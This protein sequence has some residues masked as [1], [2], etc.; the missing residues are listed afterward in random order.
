MKA[1]PLKIL[2]PILLVLAILATLVIL[3]TRPRY[4]GKDEETTDPA[5]YAAIDT[6]ETSRIEDSAS[7]SFLVPRPTVRVCRLYFETTAPVTVDIEI[8]PSDP[9][10][11]DL[12]AGGNTTHAPLMFTLPNLGLDITLHAEFHDAEKKAALRVRVMEE[13]ETIFE[14]TFWSENTISETISIPSA[15]KLQDSP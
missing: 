7:S 9:L 5:V 8:P 11:V 1:S 4:E 12:S 15:T 3:A 6:P 13:N 14:K 2:S 10:N